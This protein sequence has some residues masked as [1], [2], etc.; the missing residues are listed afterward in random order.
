MAKSKYKKKMLKLL[1]NSFEGAPGGGSGTLN[2]SVGYGTP[3]YK[4]QDPKNFSS[5]DKTTD[6]FEPNTSKG[7][8]SVPTPSDRPDRV[9]N[10]QGLN[11]TDSHET[12]IK[13]GYPDGT[14]VTNPMGNDNNK[15]GGDS[16]DNSDAASLEGPEKAQDGEEKNRGGQESDIDKE[17]DGKNKGVGQDTKIMSPAGAADD[18]QADKPL[19]PDQSYDKPV[20]QLFQ[21]KQTPSPDEIMSALQYELSN[22]VKK[23]KHIAKQQVLKNLKQD[24]HYYTNLGMLNIDDKKMKVDETTFSK[25]KA[26]LDDM[27]AARKNRNPNPVSTSPELNKIFKELSDRRQ[28]IR[29]KTF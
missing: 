20:D 4:Q 6:H 16:L 14:I 22:M 24:P 8:A 19:N 3:N 2:Y 15:E 28:S 7:S 13:T 17:P 1:E 18:A 11:G 23:D 5:S 10:N 29:N 27:I 12:P 21:K 26:V 9:G 25:T